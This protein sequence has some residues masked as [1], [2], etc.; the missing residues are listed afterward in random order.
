MIAVETIAALQDSLADYRRA[1]D[2]IALVPTMGALH[3]GHLSLVRKA[4]SLAGRTVVSIFVNPTQF[5]P[6]EDFSRYPRLPERDCQLLEQEQ[7]DLVF[8]P[9]TVEMYPDGWAVTV[10]PGAVGETFEGK[11]RPGHFAGTLT[12][13]AKLFNLFRPDAAVFGQK[14]AQQLFLIRRMTADLNFPIEIAVTE[15]KREHDGL[16]MS[17]RNVYL[18]PAGREQATVLYRALRAGVQAIRNRATSLQ[19]VQAVMQETCA[20]TPEF[21][22]DYLTAVDNRTFTETDPLPSDPLLIIAG[23][24]DGVRLIDNLQVTVQ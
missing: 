16:A 22:V 12:V 10:Q 2:R 7:V 24:L 9:T 5:G 21:S 15:T 3:E 11:V 18:S 13:V 4:R 8:L 23:R 1:G 20:Q 17:S 19:A 14:D 6:R